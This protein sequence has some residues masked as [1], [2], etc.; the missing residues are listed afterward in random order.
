M[1]FYPDAPGGAAVYALGS[2][3]FDR[4]EITLSPGFH[5]GTSFVIEALGNAPDHPFVLSAELDGAPLLRPF[6]RHE[7]ITA[8]GS[9]T[10]QM[11][12]TAPS[13]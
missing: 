3:L 9:L 6:V 11:S 1:G 4:V 7:D 10:L 2:P 12:A 8:G 5:D 13:P